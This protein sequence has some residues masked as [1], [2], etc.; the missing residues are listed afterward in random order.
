MEL[1][2]I[3][4]IVI[5]AVACGLTSCRGD[6]E[7][8]TPAHAEHAASAERDPQATT[9]SPAVAASAIRGVVRDDS[10]AG[11]AGVGVLA[12]ST[13]ELAFAQ[14]TADGSFTIEVNR[15]GPYLVDLETGEPSRDDHATKWVAPGTHDVVLVLRNA[16]RATILVVDDASGQPLERF[17]LRVANDETT[18]IHGGNDMADV[19]VAEHPGGEA[20]AWVRRE[21]NVLRVQAPGYA[22]AE[23]AVSPQIASAPRQTVRLAR[24]GAI[25]GRALTPGVPVAG[26]DVVA[27]RGPIGTVWPAR[28]D[29]VDPDSWFLAEYPR[30][31]GDYAGRPRQT[32]TA[33]DGAF[34]IPDLDPGTYDVVVGGAA[35]APVLVKRVRVERGATTQAGDVVL[36]PPATLRGRVV[37]APDFPIGELEWYVE[38]A[39]QPGQKLSAD[40][41]FVV[42]GL[43]VGAHRVVL[44]GPHGL[45]LAPEHRDA[46]L[47][48]G[49]TTEVV[50]DLSRSGPCRVRARVL[51]AGELVDV[52]SVETVI[53]PGPGKM[54]SSTLPKTRES[55][56]FEGDVFG[57]APV[58]FHVVGSNGLRVASARFDALGSGTKRDLELVV[59][60]GTL[61]VT[62]PENFVVPEVGTLTIELQRDGELRQRF[63]ACTA[64]V[65]AK[66]GAVPWTSLRCEVG[67]VEPG[68]YEVWVRATRP[69]VADGAGGTPGY[70]EDLLHGASKRIVAT[71]RE[72]TLLAVEY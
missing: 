49:D 25:S 61:V 46:R 44:T 63:V 64:A 34:T 20:I 60:P 37:T 3:P 8:S 38:G 33:T 39:F 54:Q 70:E 59:D 35:Y 15:P 62:L 43:G 55:G 65:P 40:G 11:A 14:S 67:W 56:V 42:E 32:K 23:V 51:H 5:L 45:M 31:L 18:G 71:A 68:E 57:G 48:A 12:L 36:G 24:G 69:S 1:R 30:D 22:S 17:G 28:E 41:T 52:R 47:H 58:T 13:D 50:F 66:Y 53:H 19:P 29:P 72:T 26:A 6:A 10:G 4:S 9:R 2:R 27:V 7:P 16:I 21:K